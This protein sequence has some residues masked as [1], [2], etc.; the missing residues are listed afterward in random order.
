MNVTHMLR[1]KF[2]PKGIEK[3]AIIVAEEPNAYRN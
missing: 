3:E 1:V 2:S